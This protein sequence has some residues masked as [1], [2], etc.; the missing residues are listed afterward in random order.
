MERTARRFLDSM[1]RDKTLKSLAMSEGQHKGL[2][3]MH[4]LSI[5]NSAWLPQFIRITPRVHFGGPM[6]DTA[7]NM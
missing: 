3:P 6:R 2:V 4:L 1:A 5:G 7:S